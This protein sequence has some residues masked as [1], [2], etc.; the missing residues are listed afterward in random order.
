MSRP[1]QLQI[2]QTGAWRCAMDFDAG[3]VPGEFLQ[4]ADSMARLSG[5]D[6]RMRLVICCPGE[7]GRPLPTRDVLMTWSRQ[8]GWVK[9]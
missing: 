4:A 3:E 6:A 5:T 8:E 2:N 1:A 9:A 7:N